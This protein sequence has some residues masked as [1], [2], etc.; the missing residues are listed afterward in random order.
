MHNLDYTHTHTWGV[1]M[2]FALFCSFLAVSGCNL[3]NIFKSSNSGDE[4]SGY[5]YIPIDP[6]SVS[7]VKNTTCAPNELSIDVLE[8]KRKE[9]LKKQNTYLDYIESI[10][11]GNRAIGTA[12][13][14]G[15]SE[16]A[17]EWLFF[18]DYFIDLFEEELVGSEFDEETAK[19]AQE[20]FK[21]R[22]HS[23][24]PDNAV[25]MMLEKYDTKGSVSF[26]PSNLG[27]GK[28]SYK[29]TV[30]YIN[31]DTVSM[32]FYFKK[33]YT[34]VIVESPED[35][36]SEYANYDEKISL[37]S[38]IKLSERERESIEYLVVRAPVEERKNDGTKTLITFG[39]FKD[40]DQYST[41]T[42]VDE[43][44][45]SQ[46]YEQYSIPIYVGIG[47]RVSADINVVEGNVNISGIGAIGAEAETG[48]L[49]GSLVVQT[50]GINGKSISAAL[51]IQS[52]L[53]RTTA[54][55]AIVAVGSIKA[56]LYEKDTV[57]RPR[58]VGI[59]VPFR[60]DIDLVN[61]IV[62]EMSKDPVIWK[63]SCKAS[64]TP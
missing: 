39:G 33:T 24:L 16:D 52:E 56:L 29:V 18:Q 42:E 21:Q 45:I 3:K 1:K 37:T 50:L 10:R 28:G 49:K 30:D 40:P 41:V 13:K 55:N 4:R 51:P 22:L 7:V 9:E 38:N 48:N 15:S 32:K 64:I 53:N 62:S 44:F 43:Y 47:L 5:T 11:G 31:A 54:Q 2:R 6:F 20:D 46:G 58:V 35:G 61:K 63:P 26:G 23:L 25:R 14:E 57:V 12:V 59:Y 36:E 8:A 17:Q 34:P 27:A 19:D 60:A